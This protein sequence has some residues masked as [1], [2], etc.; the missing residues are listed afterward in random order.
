MEFNKEHAFT[1]IRSDIATLSEQSEENEIRAGVNR[2]RGQL[3][4][5]MSTGLI[6]IEEASSLES[7]MAVART[8]AASRLAK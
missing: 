7:E 2:V 1:Y 5:L 3:G 8:T 4:L 6:T